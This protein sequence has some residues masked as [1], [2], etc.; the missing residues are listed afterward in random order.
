MAVLV[1]GRAVFFD[2]ERGFV[3]AAVVAIA[4]ETKKQLAI[5][6]FFDLGRAGAKGRLQ[7]FL[8]KIVGF[9][10]VA[11]DIDNSYSIVRHVYLR[12]RR[13]SST[14]VASTTRSSG[15]SGFPC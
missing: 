11:V 14:I 13:T 7:I 9:A 3:G 5:G 8:K 12:S 2:A 10:H 15:K 1:G 4:F 6:N